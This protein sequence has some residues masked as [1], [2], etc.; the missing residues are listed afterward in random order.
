MVSRI[1]V[2]LP[3]LHAFTLIELLVV[4]TVVA[5]LVSIAM[6]RHFGA[7]ERSRETVLL[8]NLR[9]LRKSID[10][11][12]RDRRRYPERLE[13][14]VDA[15]YLRS[16]PVDPITESAATWVTVPA[17]EGDR[18]GIADEKSGAVGT[19]KSGVPFDQ[20]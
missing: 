2:S 18:T 6:P 8:E 11:Y 19:S 4:M 12:Y 10:D 5:L 14:L 1:R 7:V 20:F 17:H 3:R 13:A 15:R 16:V 9:A